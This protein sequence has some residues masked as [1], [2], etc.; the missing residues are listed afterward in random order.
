M[1]LQTTRGI[2]RRSGGLK[3][4]LISPVYSLCALHLLVFPQVWKQ[5]SSCLKDF[6]NVLVGELMKEL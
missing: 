5:S 2:I 6:E 1:R 4:L 3:V